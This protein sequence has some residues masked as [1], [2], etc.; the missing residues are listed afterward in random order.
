MS[1]ARLSLSLSATRLYHRRGSVAQLTRLYCPSQLYVW[2]T[3]KGGDWT[4]ESTTR[5][6]E[7][8]LGPRVRFQLVHGNWC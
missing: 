7:S 3:G 1:F 4:H 6:E 5:F 2:L 8:F